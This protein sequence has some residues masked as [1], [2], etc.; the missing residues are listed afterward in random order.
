LPG[1]RSSLII[2][3]ALLLGGAVTIL[4]GGEKIHNER[5]IPRNGKHT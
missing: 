3:A 4:A 5:H 2:A 1:A